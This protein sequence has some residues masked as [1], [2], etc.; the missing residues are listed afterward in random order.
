MS[1]SEQKSYIE[2]SNEAGAALFS[3]SLTGEIVMLNMLRFRE[4]ADYSVFP[5]LAPD[6]PILGK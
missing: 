3:R 5:E 1:D 2:V 4:T 6:T